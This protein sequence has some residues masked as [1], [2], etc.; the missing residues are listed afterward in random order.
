MCEICLRRKTEM[1]MK[2]KK[3]KMKSEKEFAEE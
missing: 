2:N 1:K 3:I